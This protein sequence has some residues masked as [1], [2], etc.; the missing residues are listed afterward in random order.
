[1]MRAHRYAMAAVVVALL[2]AFAAYAAEPVKRSPG[3]YLDDKAITAKV[4]AALVEDPGVKA[5]QIKVETFEG[6][7]Q[8]SGFVDGPEQITRAAEIAKGVE[9]V[10]SVK[11]DLIVRSHK[12]N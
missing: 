1:M 8:L 5:L 7:V 3:Q 9:G 6:I 4:K 12:S 2:A 10:K 11:N